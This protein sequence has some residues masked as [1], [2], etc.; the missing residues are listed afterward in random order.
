[1]IQFHL[2]PASGVPAY[3]QI[4]QQVRE[5]ISLGVLRPGDQL[6]TIKEVVATLAINPNTVMKAYREL[7]LAGVVDARRGQGTFVAPTV[8]GSPDR[9]Y[10]PLRA[11]LVEWLSRA[12]AAGLDDDAI[13][14]LVASTL[15]TQLIVRA[16]A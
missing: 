2:D 11:E 3:L 15:R 10:A 6:P 13:R 14:A 1:M 8:G 12:R 4:V 5:A 7:D 9:D 16:V